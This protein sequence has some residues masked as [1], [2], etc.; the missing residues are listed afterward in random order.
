MAHKALTALDVSIDDESDKGHTERIQDI[1]SRGAVHVR[2]EQGTGEIHPRLAPLSVL[3][4]F[5]LDVEKIAL[6]RGDNPDAP[7]GLKKVTRTL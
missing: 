5:Y 6:S 2:L 7:P 3:Q 4:R 1:L